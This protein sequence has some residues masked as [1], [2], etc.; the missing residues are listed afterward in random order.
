MLSAYQQYRVISAIAAGQPAS[1]MAAHA[2]LDFSP[3]THFNA[4]E[5]ETGENLAP[6][7]ALD[8]RHCPSAL[9]LTIRIGGLA[10]PLENGR[11]Q[12]VQ[13]PHQF[14]RVQANNLILSP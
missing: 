14:E 10:F 12:A 13:S 5:S 6:V 8:A 7:I 2:G 4:G 3:K 11:V 9:I 1:P